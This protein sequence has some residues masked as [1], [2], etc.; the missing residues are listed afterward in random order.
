ML[1]LSLQLGNDRVRIRSQDL[2]TEAQRS[3]QL[4]YSD[5][6]VEL[7]FTIYLKV[8]I[9]FTIGKRQGQD[10]IPRPLDWEHSDLTNC[11]I[12][13]TMLVCVLTIYLN[14]EIVFTI[15]KR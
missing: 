9:V 13:T 4:R 1:K 12:P 11:A 7:C 6:H 2:F 8:E 15:G 14:V 5:H 3:N 10:S